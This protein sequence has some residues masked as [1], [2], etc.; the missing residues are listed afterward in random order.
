VPPVS[1]GGA[2]YRLRPSVE[3]FV[4][5][6]GVL[7]FVCPGGEDLV[8]RDPS[9]EDIALVEL[10]KTTSHTA[11]SLATL[12]GV[13]AASVQAQLDSLVSAGLVLRRDGPGSAPLAGEDAARF[14]RQ[15]PYLAELGD[16]MALQR[17]IRA[18]TVAVIGCGGL[19]TWAIA[20]LASIGVGNLVL[21]D[22]DTVEL[23]NLNR[24]ILYARADVGE[25]KVAT[26]RRWLQ[27]FDPAISVRGVDGR[28][29]SAADAAAIV[30][31]SDAVVLAAD[32][33]PYEIGRWVNT[34][35]VDAEIPFIVAGQLPPILKVGPTYVPGAG[36]CLSCHETGLAAESY[37]YEDYAAYRA[38]DSGIASTVGPASCI[39]GG[40]IGLE[41]L[42]LLAGQPPATRE[43]AFIVHMRTLDV[44]RA[45]L[46]RNPL[47]ATCKHLW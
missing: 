35:C 42:H 30:R 20:A 47:C 25:A 40:L 3:P 4:D 38:S 31:G 36:P 18:A 24:Q 43:F 7:C 5:R 17:S 21:V 26:T 13:Q 46:S 39:A 32:W 27:S 44:R 22:D 37:A 29:E 33:P 34:A 11:G 19:G 10:L 28:V 45:P 23:S 9:S 16:E 12:L 1:P 14:S 8:V 15:L 41:M 6:H 2:R